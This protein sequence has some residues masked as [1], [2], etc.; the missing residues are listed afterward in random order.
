MSSIASSGFYIK[1]NLTEVHKAISSQAATQNYDTFPKLSK[2]T[3]KDEVE[4]DKSVKQ[5]NQ[6]GFLNYTLNVYA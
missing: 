3:Q 2:E 4:F 1:D 5:K 6:E